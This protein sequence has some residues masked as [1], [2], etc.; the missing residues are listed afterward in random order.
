[1]I[2]SLMEVLTCIEEVA[3]VVCGNATLLGD[4]SQSFEIAGELVKLFGLL[5]RPFC[6]AGVRSTRIKHRHPQPGRG[7]MKCAFGD[8]TVA[9][10]GFGRL[11]GFL[12]GAA[13]INFEVG[14]FAAGDPTYSLI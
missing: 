7:I 4:L 9:L 3:A 6:L 1:S 8:M 14:I 5:E 11:P 12:I 2:E 13:Q 10:D